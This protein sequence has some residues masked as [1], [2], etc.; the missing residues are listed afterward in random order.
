MDSMWSFM[1]ACSQ[2]LSSCLWLLVEKALYPEVSNVAHPTTKACYCSFTNLV[3]ASQL[4]KKETHLTKQRHYGITVPYFSVTKSCDRTKHTSSDYLHHSRAGSSCTRCYMHPTSAREDQSE[5]NTM[6]SSGHQLPRAKLP[7]E[8]FA[9]IATDAEWG[10]PN[11]KRIMQR[12]WRVFK[13][14][15]SKEKGIAGKKLWGFLKGKIHLI[16]KHPVLVLDHY[17]IL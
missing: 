3:V 16:E 2:L 8:A 6:S 17:L 9:G 12:V 4:W 11:Q 7:S 14:S 10:E 15:S 5:M 13:G 1:L